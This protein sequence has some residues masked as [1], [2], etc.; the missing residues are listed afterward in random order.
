VKDKELIE[1]MALMWIE[2]GGDE[3]SFDDSAREL[4]QEI[5]L[6]VLQATKNREDT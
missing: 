5:Q 1:R 2:N 3:I 6:Q 4:R